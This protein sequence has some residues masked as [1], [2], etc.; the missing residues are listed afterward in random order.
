MAVVFVANKKPYDYWDLR[1][2]LESVVSHAKSLANGELNFFLPPNV[3]DELAH[4]T[5]VFSYD[6]LQIGINEAVGLAWI[7]RIT[8][9]KPVYSDQIIDRLDKVQQSAWLLQRELVDLDTGMDPAISLAGKFLCDVLER[10]KQWDTESGESELGEYR[11]IVG[12]LAN[13]IEMAKHF[14]TQRMPATCGRPTGAAKAGVA[15][16]NFIARLEFAARAAGGSWTLNKND[17]SGTL[18]AALEVLRAH[19]PEGLIPAR[20]KHPYSSYQRILTR[21]RSDWSSS[22]LPAKILN[23][24]AH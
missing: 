4:L 2:F 15:L 13:T 19:L 8:F 14:V 5:K 3:V 24:N 11:A 17:Q 1:Q 12:I 16:N 6:L 21:A 23:N 10:W 22:P 9:Y 18:I 7:D 20:N